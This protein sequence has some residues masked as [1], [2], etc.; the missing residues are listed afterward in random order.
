[1]DEPIA[2]DVMGAPGIVRKDGVWILDAACKRLIHY[3]P[4][5]FYTAQCEKALHQARP[6]AHGPGA[7]ERVHVTLIVSHS[8]NLRCRYCCVSDIHP[9]RF[10]DPAVASAVPD[11]VGHKFPLGPVT[12]SFFGGEPTLA[13]DVIEQ[14]C[15]AFK[16]MSR[17]TGRSVT[18]SLATNGVFSDK[19]VGLLARYRFSVLLSLDGPPVVHNL[20]RPVTSGK[21]SYDSVV[22][23]LHKLRAIGLTVS[24]SATITRTSVNYWPHLVDLAVA[25][26]VRNVQFNPVSPSPWSD[27][28]GP[29]AWDRPSPEVYAN[30]AIAAFI[31]GRRRGVIVSNPVFSRL[32][33]PSRYYCDLIAANSALCVDCDGTLLACSDAQADNHPFRVASTLGYWDTER[34]VFRQSNSYR[35]PPVDELNTCQD[36]FAR[37]HCAGGCRARALQATPDGNP[38]PFVCRVVRIMLPRYLDL[39]ASEVAP[40]VE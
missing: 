25:H 9:R 24:L 10:M 6:S 33:R 16:A 38:D 11:Y 4:E 20:Q 17:R 22:R 13:A 34:G 28:K 19:V 18:F 23:T 37:Y 40:R 7:G 2:I 1:M 14:S 8:C 36:C 31:T 3:T 29:V 15:E 12:V 27:R 39:M 30:A 32:F 5:A 26:N 35:S 21:G